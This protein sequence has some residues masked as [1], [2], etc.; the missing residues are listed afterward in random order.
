MKTQEH[1]AFEIVLQRPED[2]DTLWARLWDLDRHTA[3][4][5][6]TKVRTVGGEKLRFGSRFIARTGIGPL[7]LNDRM[8]VREWDPPHRAVVEKIG[9]RLGGTIT[10]KITP[11][12]QGSR[13]QWQQ[14]Y[15]VRGLP[16]AIA[17][18]FRS[19]VR[20]GYLHSLQK[21]LG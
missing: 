18:R 5:P 12:G 19:V 8:M 10:V 13:V 3:S 15:S 14:T 6:L 20:R 1:P 16:D 7:V 11:D 2:P 21:I 17:G 9:S 4:I